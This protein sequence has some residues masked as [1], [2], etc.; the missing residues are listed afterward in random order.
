MCCFDKMNTMLIEG[1]KEFFSDKLRIAVMF[2]LFTL[3]CLSMW[4]YLDD[5]GALVVGILCAGVS[6]QQFYRYYLQKRS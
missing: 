1:L 3:L 6:A 5:E 2:A 4:L